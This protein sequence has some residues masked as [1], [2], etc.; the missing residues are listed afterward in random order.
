MKT[1]SAALSLALVISGSMPAMALNCAGSPGYAQLT[2]AEVEALVGTS[3]A[4]YPASAPYHDQEYHT[5]SASSAAGNIIDYKKGPTDPR[6]PST[7]VGSYSV[8]SGGALQYTYT[9]GATYT[10]GV[11]G[12]QTSGSGTYDFCNGVTPLTGRV[13]IVVAVGSPTAC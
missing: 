1:A 5:G 9:G 8:S 11:W 12:S 3:M 2:Q 10:Y 6:D 7:Q 13:R 4:C